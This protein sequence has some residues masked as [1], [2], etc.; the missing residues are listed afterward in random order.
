[1]ANLLAKLKDGIRRTPLFSLAYGV[2][3]GWL[4]RSWEA[5]GRPVPPPHIVKQ[6]AIRD[7]A[8][9]Y[10]VSTF[11]ETGTFLGDMIAGVA[12]VFRRIYTIELSPELHQRAI[13]RFAGKPH[14]RLLQG[15]SG[16]VLGRVL[17][18][19]DGPAVFWLDGHFSAGPTARADL[20]TPIERELALIAAHPLKLRHVILIDDARAFGHEADYPP[21]EVVERWAAAEGYSRFEV[22]NDI[23]RIHHPPAHGR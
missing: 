16:Q 19:L 20:S 1:M 4:V 18:E 13:R 5:A 2:R 7:L 22:E 9:R 8:S 23:I 14:I 15:D 3:Q 21:L 12:G 17:G 10:G 6:R 11:V